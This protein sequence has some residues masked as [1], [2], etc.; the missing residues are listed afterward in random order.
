MR[1]RLLGERQREGRGQGPKKN[2]GSKEG[3]KKA[4]TAA[5]AE[6]AGDKSKSGKDKDKDDEDEAWAVVEEEEQSPQ[7]LATVADEAKSRETELYDSGA[8]RHMSPFC[9]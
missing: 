4:D 2:Q 1:A 9:E 6:Q 8:S 7:T 5:G 3:G